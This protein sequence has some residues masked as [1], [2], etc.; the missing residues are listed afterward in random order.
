MAE[1]SQWL[2]GSTLVEIVD[3]GGLLRAVVMKAGRAVLRRLSPAAEVHTE[4]DHLRSSLRRLAF[5]HGSP[6]SLAASE[7]AAAYGASRLDGLLL[8]PLAGDLDDG[9]LVVIP[10]GPLHAV[11]WSVL[12][13]CAGRPVTV[14][15]SATLWLKARASSEAQPAKPTVLVAGPGLAHGTAEV[16]ALGRAYRG[17]KSFTGQR[18]TCAAV[19]AALDGAAVAHVAAHGHFRADNPLFS[20][21]ELADGPLTVYDLEALH[22]TPRLLVLS[23]CDSGV[24]DVRPG[25]E[26]MGLAA[27]VLSLGTRVLVASTMPVPDAETRR[28]MLALHTGLRAGLTPATA[29]ARAQSQLTS[30]GRPAGAGFVC[31]GAGHRGLRG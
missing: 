10:T 1:L 12:P 22:R 11:P 31:M 2:G 18:A 16:R 24:S 28:L 9:T 6:A 19:C 13:S 15:P 20:S 7:K 26:L 8:G 23:A 14:S 30:G 21:L 4:L 25:D 5:R 27:A 3:D 17:A 29:L